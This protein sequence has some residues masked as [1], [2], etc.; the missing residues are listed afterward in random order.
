[1]CRPRLAR[2]PLLRRLTRLRRRLL[3]DA[4]LFRG[5]LRLLVRR[6][7]DF[8]LVNRFAVLLVLNGLAAIMRQR[9]HLQPHYAMNLRELCS[10]TA[11]EECGRLRRNT[12]GH[13]REEQA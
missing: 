13:R 4:V 10:L 9:L 8:G 3:V 7:P 11:G 1:P 6:E 2:T 12:A 5:T